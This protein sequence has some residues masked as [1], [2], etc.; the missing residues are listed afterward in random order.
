M[1]FRNLMNREITNTKKL[2]IDVCYLAVSLWDEEVTEKQVKEIYDICHSGFSPH[3]VLNCIC[4]HIDTYSRIAFATENEAEKNILTKLHTVFVKDLFKNPLLKSVDGIDEEKTASLTK[5]HLHKNSY[6]ILTMVGK[7]EAI[8]NSFR[9]IEEARGVNYYSDRFKR[10]CE[11]LQCIL[12]IR[13]VDGTY[14]VP[15]PNEEKVHFEKPRVISV[16]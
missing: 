10:Q 3:W 2:P 13:N 16:K 15:R 11:F 14:S 4:K 6:L 7:V 9:A 8:N 12:N 1:F 5:Q